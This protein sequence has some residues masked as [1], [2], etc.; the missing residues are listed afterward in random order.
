MEWWQRRVQTIMHS[1]SIYIC[2]NR[3]R[4]T[5]STPRYAKFFDWSNQFN[6]GR[7]ELP[8]RVQVS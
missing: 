6:F 2:A 1:H 4:R 5:S 7:L 3:S 8:R